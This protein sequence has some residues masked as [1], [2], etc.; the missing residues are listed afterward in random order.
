MNA[1]N[2]QLI[3]STRKTCEHP[4]GGGFCAGNC[5]YY[6]LNTTAVVPVF[7]ELILWGVMDNIQVTGKK[8]IS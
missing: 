4:L 7:T 8:K 1:P 6:M 3:H 5:T 2:G